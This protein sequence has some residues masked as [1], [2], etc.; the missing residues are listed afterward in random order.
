MA[1]RQPAN[2]PTP[3]AHLNNLQDLI[4]T[5]AARALVSLTEQMERRPIR[6]PQLID[7][8]DRVIEALD[9]STIF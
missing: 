8:V 6:M 9:V 4:D 5:G 7:T 1:N 3:G 2:D